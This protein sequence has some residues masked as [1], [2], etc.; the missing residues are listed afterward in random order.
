MTGPQSIQANWLYLLAVFVTV[1]GSILLVP[2]VGTV[3]N[4]YV[5]E[6]A[7]YLVSV[8]FLARRSRW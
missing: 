2:K 6:L 3:V 8:A 1:A 7:F 5:I 4:L